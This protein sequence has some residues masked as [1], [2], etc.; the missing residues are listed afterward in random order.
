MQRAAV[1]ESL[2][3]LERDTERVRCVA[4]R[5]D[6]ERLKLRLTLRLRDRHELQR[7]CE[8]EREPDRDRDLDTAVPRSL[9]GLCCRDHS[10]R[11]H[12]HGDRR[13]LGVHEHDIDA[14]DELRDR[15]EL[16]RD[17][18]AGRR[19]P[20]EL[21]DARRPCCCALFALL[22]SAPKNIPNVTTCY[23]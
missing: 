3:Q 7:E 20:P 21:A 4:D 6:R 8:W 12:I 1:D 2:D 10:H 22:T 17:L 19:C 16:E 13:E 9:V 23:K 5:G 11:E 14:E 18:L 15:E